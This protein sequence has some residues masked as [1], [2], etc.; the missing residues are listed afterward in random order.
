MF[1]SV[2]GFWTEAIPIAS[3]IKT[4]HLCCLSLALVFDTTSPSA[5]ACAIGI[6]SIGR[7]S[8]P[9]LASPRHGTLTPGRISVGR[10]PCLRLG[11]DGSII[12]P[13]GIIAIQ[14]ATGCFVD[15][16]TRLAPYLAV[17]DRGEIRQAVITEQKCIGDF[18]CSLYQNLYR[19]FSRILQRR[20]P[21]FSRGPVRKVFRQSDIRFSRNKR[22]AFPSRLYRGRCRHFNNPPISIF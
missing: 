4:S 2:N 17:V 10:P 7:P 16:W 11:L 20:L 18:V 15:G 3:D 21:Q 22:E 6:S 13:D 9:R 1:R 8:E 12:V 14:L 5:G 19:W